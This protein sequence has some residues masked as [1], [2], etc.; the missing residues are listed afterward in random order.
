LF[1]SF[2]FYAS[3]FTKRKLRIIYWNYQIITIFLA[4][5]IILEA[6]ILEGLYFSVIFSKSLPNILWAEQI[7]G[8]IQINLVICSVYTNFAIEMAKLLGFGKK[9]NKIFCFALNF[10]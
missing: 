7:L 5:F 3:Y 6:I 4:I 10:S 2:I 8:N 9:K 1:S